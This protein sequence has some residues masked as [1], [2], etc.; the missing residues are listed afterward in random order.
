M[1]FYSWT[2]KAG[3]I[4]ALASFTALAI[5]GESSAQSTTKGKKSA[6]Q[7]TP[8]PAQPQAGAPA[9]PPKPIIKAKHGA[10]VVQCEKVKISPTLAT[11]IEQIQG[12]KLPAAKDG[13]VEIEQ[14]AALQ[15]VVPEDR[16]NIRVTIIIAKTFRGK[17]PLSIMRVLAPLGVYLPTGTAIEVDGKGLSRVEFSVCAPVGCF[18]QT[19]MNN[20]FLS[21]MKGGKKG[22]VVIYLAPGQSVGIPIS[23]AGFSKA[24]AAF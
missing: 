16:K 2:I 7:S 6:P 1:K 24:F 19:E 21:K 5:G 13:A 17:K 20:A 15:S 3:L 8:A 11:R 14:C 22:N 12:R 18:A 10:W 4:C 23:L 9:R